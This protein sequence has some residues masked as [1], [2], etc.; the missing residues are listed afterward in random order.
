[1]SGGVDSTACALLLRDQHP[2]EGFFMRLAQPACAA[3]EE[4]VQSIAARLGIP[5]HI[6][7]L[8]QEFEAKV[9]EYFSAEYF[10]GLTPNPCVVCNREIKFGLFLD[11]MISAGMS[12][13]ATGHYARLQTTG[14]LHRLFKGVDPKK[15]QSY[16]L[17]RLSQPQLA[18][19]LFPLGDRTKEN[20]YRFVAECGF[21]DFQGL[22]SQ[23]VCFLDNNE[24]GQF[25][26][27]RAKADVTSGPILSSEGKQLG[28]HN[29]LFRYTIGQRRGLGIAAAAPLY[30]VDLD[31]GRNA[32]I[33]G[34]NQELLR[35]RTPV[36]HFHWLS[37]TPPDTAKTY[38]V[39][40]RYSHPGA[41]AQVTLDSHGRGEILFHEAQK[42]I[43]PGQFAVVYEGDELLGSGIIVRDPAPK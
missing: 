24:I 7:D 6:V 36:E 26:Q 9:L 5:L 11:A 29:G 30:V 22:E 28:Q 43:A 17:S 18:R 31:V 40:I 12:A 33:V 42:A 34:S 37:G 16:F 8:R 3:Q 25:L 27:D 35:D 20:T 13:M 2:V 23:D 15:D 41:S 1:M 10:R 39:R 38:I 19:V 4:R 21:T 14:N 32:V